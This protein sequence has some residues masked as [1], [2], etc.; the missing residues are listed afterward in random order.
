VK[1]YTIVWRPQARDDL[2]ALYEWITEQA[3]PDTAFE[4]T[5]KIEAHAN[6]L[7]NFP[8]RGTPRDD[9]APRS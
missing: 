3:D 9:L 8:E 1:S 7:A 2:L 4:Y 6:T 5:S